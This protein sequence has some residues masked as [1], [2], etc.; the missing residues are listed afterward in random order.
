SGLFVWTLSESNP[1]RHDDVAVFVLA[2]GGFVGAEL[3]GGLG[4]F[5][6][7]ADVAC[8]HHPQELQDVLGVEANHEPRSLINAC[9]PR[10]ALASQATATIRP[11]ISQA[12]SIPTLC[13]PATPTTP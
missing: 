4:V 8:A 1:H 6:F 12:T 13:R 11:E 2:I 9:R 10:A 7:K 5:E 3:A